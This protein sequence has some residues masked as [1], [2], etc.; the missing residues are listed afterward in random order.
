MLFTNYTWNYY[1]EPQANACY[2]ARKRSCYWPRGKMIG[3]TGGI[4]GMIFLRG[5]RRDYDSWLALGNV[6]W[7]WNDVQRYF[8]K[9]V[10]PA[11]NHTHPMG[12]VVLNDFNFPYDDILDLVCNASASLGVPRVKEIGNDGTAIG[13]TRAPGTVENG[14]RMSTG[15]TYLGRVSK[16][17]NLHVIKHAHAIKI[18]FE[19]SGQRATSV[20]FM[21]REKH[22]MT[23]QFQRELVVSAGTIESAKLLLLSGV[24]PKSHLDEMKIPVIHDL[25]IGNNLQNH[26]MSSIYFTL[27]VRPKQRITTEHAT[28]N[29]FDYLLHSKGPFSSPSTV[30]VVSF[31]NTLPKSDVPYPTTEF[32]NIFYHYSDIGAVNLTS[33]SLSMQPQYADYLRRVVNRTDVMHTFNVLAHPKSTGLIRLKS[34]SYKD[35]PRIIPNYLTAPGDLDNMLHGVRF[36]ERLERTAAYRAV[37]ATILRIPIKECDKLKFRSD[38]YWRCYIKY[39]TSTVFHITGTVKMGPPTDV[40]TCVNSQLRLHGTWNVRVADASIMP[41]VVSANTNAASIMIAER[42][43]DFIKTDWAALKA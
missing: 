41:N 10:T 40:T 8:R 28:Q 1:T 23:A 36:L 3:G 35:K 25:P 42:A 33:N 2:A 37:N 20:T 24:G 4:N 43:A 30:P 21:W 12:H 38:D 6:G 26:V 9:A 22:R 5:N 13:C 19:R 39:F 15:K 11:G 29:M 7:G 27:N 18:N 17:P 16:R 14:R 31:V 34:K 32:H